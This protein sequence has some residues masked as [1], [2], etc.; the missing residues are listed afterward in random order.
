MLLPLPNRELITGRK[1]G[2]WINGRRAGIF[3]LSFLLQFGGPTIGIKQ[4]TDEKA[5]AK[6]NNESL[7]PPW[8]KPG[9]EGN[10]DAITQAQ[11]KH[12]RRMSV[13]RQHESPERKRFADGRP[14]IRIVVAS[15]LGVGLQDWP[16]VLKQT[17]FIDLDFLS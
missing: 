6:R 7:Q 3:A 9:S 11:E 17:R 2:V 12:F 1:C 13:D 14:E 8:R 10:S 16:R 4:W 15:I 5:R